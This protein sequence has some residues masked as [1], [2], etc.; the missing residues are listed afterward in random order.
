MQKQRRLA[1]KV[2]LLNWFNWNCVH[3][4]KN[5]GLS[6]SRCI[7][8]SGLGQNRRDQLVPLIMYVCLKLQVPRIEKPGQ[9]CGVL[10]TSANTYSISLYCNVTIYFGFESQYF[11]VVY[12]FLLQSLTYSLGSIPNTFNCLLKSRMISFF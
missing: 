8:C 3:M 10:I 11:K 1:F 4:N 9:W 12:V 5:K 6:I 2:K 7:V